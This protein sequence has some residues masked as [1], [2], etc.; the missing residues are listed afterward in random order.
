MPGDSPFK[1]GNRGNI[2]AWVYSVLYNAFES[3]ISI[4]QLKS[5]GHQ[6]MRQILSVRVN[7]VMGVETRIRTSSTAMLFVI[8]RQI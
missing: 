4:I 6:N 1:H 5:R 2:L 8:L 7:A 3:Y